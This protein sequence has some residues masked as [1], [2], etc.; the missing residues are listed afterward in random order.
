M[1]IYEDYVLEHDSV[2]KG[3]EFEKCVDKNVKYIG[4]KKQDDHCL[5]VGHQCATCGYFVL[6]V[7]YLDEDFKIKSIKEYK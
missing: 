1:N 5:K 3:H 6:T 4:T 2:E 7:I